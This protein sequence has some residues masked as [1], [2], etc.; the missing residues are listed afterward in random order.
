MLDRCEAVAKRAG[1]DPAKF[2]LKAFRST[3]ATR[4]LRQ[5]FDVRTVQHW[6]GH[7]SPGPLDLVQVQ[8]YSPTEAGAALLP[9]ILLM[10]LL[11]RWSGGLLDRYGARA[12]LVIGPLIA[13]IGFALFARPGIGGSYWTAFFPAV[14]VL[15]LGMAIGVAPLTTTVMD[16]VEQRYAGAASGINNVRGQLPEHR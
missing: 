5:G 10:F 4:M 12:P 8:G 9:L 7:K 13:A 1:L 16:A 14:L 3:Y 15:G 6:M 11:S 2:D